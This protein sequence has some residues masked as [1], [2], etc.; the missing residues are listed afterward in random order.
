MDPQTLH[1]NAG[2]VAGIFNALATFILVI[3]AISIVAAFIQALT[4]DEG[5]LVGIM[6][7]LLAA[8]LIA[9]YV[10]LSW[11]AVQIAALVAGYIQ[12]RTG[13]R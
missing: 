6:A 10:A 4:A 2:R 11:A 1:R 3:G 9:L 8:F 12:V 7:G 13:D 5:L